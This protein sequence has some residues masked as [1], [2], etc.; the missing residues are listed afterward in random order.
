MRVTCAVHTH[1]YIQV[2][3][4]SLNGHSGTNGARAQNGCHVSTAADDGIL[5]LR[6]DGIEYVARLSRYF[7]AN[8]DFADL[9]QRP[10]GEFLNV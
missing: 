6:S 1:N 5:E 4:D 8:E 2:V 7:E 10:R 3:F 9:K